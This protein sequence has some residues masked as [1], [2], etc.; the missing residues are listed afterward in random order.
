MFRAG[1]LL[2][3]IFYIHITAHQ[4]QILYV[5]QLLYFGVYYVGWLL[6]GLEF[7]SYCS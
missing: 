4:Q 1:L 6:V 5:K 7:Y 2:I 3:F